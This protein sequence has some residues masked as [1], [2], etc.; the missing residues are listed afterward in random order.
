[1][2]DQFLVKKFVA[3]ISNNNFL[4][5]IVFNYISFSFLGFMPH[6]IVVGNF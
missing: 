6:I 5:E 3:F 4:N 2:L 1:M